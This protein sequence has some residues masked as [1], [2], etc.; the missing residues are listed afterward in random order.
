MQT[1]NDNNI[2]AE[3]ELVARYIHRRVRESDLAED[4]TQEVMLRLHVDESAP[5]SIVNRQSWLR[6]AARN[7]VIDHYRSRARRRDKAP[8]DEALLASEHDESGD[9]DFSRCVARMASALPATYAEAVRLAEVEGL[10]QPEVARR[11]DLSVTGAKSRVQRGRAQLKQMV[12]E[13]CDVE[14]DR[15]GGVA[16]YHRRSTGR[17]CGTEDFPASFDGVDSSRGAESAVVVGKTFKQEGQCH[18]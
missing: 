7:I 1:A 2:V 4:L 13:C 14:F 17:N 5:H 8:L 9:R 3:R 10:T 6:T 15:R 11:L 16:D 18:E 12:E